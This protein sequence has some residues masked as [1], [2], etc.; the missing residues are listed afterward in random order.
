[1]WIELINES[2]YTSDDVDIGDIDAVSRDFVV[3][4]RGFVNVHYYY[5]PIDRGMG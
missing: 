1:M 5:I 4:K 3:I 2:V